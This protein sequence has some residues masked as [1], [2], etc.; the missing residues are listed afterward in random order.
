MWEGSLTAESGGTDR[1]IEILQD[2]KTKGKLVI[3]SK[4]NS[5]DSQVLFW[6]CTEIWTYHLRAAVWLL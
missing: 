2:R 3:H 1:D 6:F 4:E 5:D